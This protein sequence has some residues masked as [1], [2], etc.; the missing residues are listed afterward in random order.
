MFQAKNR[1]A[2]WILPPIIP[3]AE[4]RDWSGKLAD[5]AARPLELCPEFPQIARRFEAWWAHDLLD[6]PIILAGASIRLSG[7]TLYI[8]AKK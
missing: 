6:R 4:L 3:I 5:L 7:A 1:R 2:I 8:T